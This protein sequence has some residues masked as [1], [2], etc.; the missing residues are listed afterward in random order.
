MWVSVPS[1]RQ[2]LYPCTLPARFLIYLCNSHTLNFMLWITLRMLLH[3][4]CHY[5]FS[6][7]HTKS[8]TGKQIMGK[9]EYLAKDIDEM[10][11][12]SLLNQ[13]KAPIHNWFCLFVWVMGLEVSHEKEMRESSTRQGRR[14][15]R[16]DFSLQ[17]LIFWFDN[18]DCFVT[19]GMLY[20]LWEQKPEINSC[21]ALVA[22]LH[23]CS[24]PAMLRKGWRGIQRSLVWTLHD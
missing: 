4:T 21:T 2:K 6:T 15:G 10:L 18:S 20:G 19:W 16:E 5:Y 11:C 12:V 23:R 3:Y 8:C 13:N 9:T 24:S 14:K 17:W 1:E 22:K 7:S